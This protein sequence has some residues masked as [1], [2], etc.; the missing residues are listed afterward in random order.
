L[1]KTGKPIV[2][3]ADLAILKR[4]FPVSHAL[5]MHDDLMTRELMRH[6]GAVHAVQTA[7]EDDGDI[8]TRW[9]TLY[10]TATGEPLLQATLVINKPA[11]PEGLLDRLLDGT[12]LFGSLLIEAG[13]AVRM[14]DRTIYRAGPPGGVY[15][16]VWGRRQRMLYAMGDGL[17]CD[18]DEC[19]V[20][21]ASLRKL[22]T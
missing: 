4:D 13:I 2:P 21:E 8:V 12:R 3:N 5:L 14:T 1:P 18:V 11:L 16:G 15:A 7:I 20:E 22:K 17:I 9:S 10:Q 6:F 19:L